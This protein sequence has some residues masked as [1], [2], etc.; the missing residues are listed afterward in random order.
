MVKYVQIAPKDGQISAPK[1][2]Q[3]AP[4]V[5]QILAPKDDQISQGDILKY[6]KNVNQSIAKLLNY[7]L[8]THQ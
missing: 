3:I 5:G 2:G 1:Y 4:K 6:L 8:N 7:G